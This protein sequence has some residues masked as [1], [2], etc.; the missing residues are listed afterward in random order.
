MA[1]A[2][3]MEEGGAAAR[4]AVRL[5]EG[6]GAAGGISEVAANSDDAELQRVLLEQLTPRPRSDT[7]GGELQEGECF[8][9][10]AFAD[11]GAFADSHAA[12]ADSHAAFADSEA[13]EAEEGL[14]VL[15]E[16]A[17]LHVFEWAL[18]CD[19]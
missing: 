8:P 2:V 4:E 17:P 7:L 6:Q 3:E 10:A 5:S 16:R 11:S 19:A 1:D 15:S 18:R 9:H 12:F 14:H 13:E